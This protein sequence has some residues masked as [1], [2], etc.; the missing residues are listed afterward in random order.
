MLD[1][2]VEAHKAFGCFG[3]TAR[4]T[5]LAATAIAPRRASGAKYGAQDFHGRHLMHKRSL[6]KSLKSAAARQR[7]LQVI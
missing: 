4:V 2:V 6:A 1:D 5:D 3:S 7:A